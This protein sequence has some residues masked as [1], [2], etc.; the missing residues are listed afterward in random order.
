MVMYEDRA[1]GKEK[2]ILGERVWVGWR[3]KRQEWEVRR[4]TIKEKPMA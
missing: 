3:G 1:R 4:H 2:F